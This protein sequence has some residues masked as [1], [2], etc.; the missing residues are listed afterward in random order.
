MDDPVPT[1][2]LI[3]LAM[4]EYPFTLPG[5]DPTCIDGV[6]GKLREVWKIHPDLR[7]TQLVFNFAGATHS[8][9]EI[10]Y[11]GDDAL[12]RGFDNFESQEPSGES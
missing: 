3:E 9:P 12:L 7:L 11:L 6:V 1:K 4:D 5:H 8:C 2:R 10:F